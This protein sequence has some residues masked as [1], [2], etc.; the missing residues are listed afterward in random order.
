MLLILLLTG[1]GTEHVMVGRF[2]PDFFQGL[3]V[4]SGL[5]FPFFMV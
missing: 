4:R 1:Y 2:C 5:F 3:S